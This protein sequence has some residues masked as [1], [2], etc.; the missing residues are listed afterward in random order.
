MICPV[1]HS[2]FS[3]EEAYCWNDGTLLIDENAEQ[4]TVVRPGFHPPI[5]GRTVPVDA[6]PEIPNNYPRGGTNPRPKLGLGQGLLIGVLAMLVV[7]LLVLCVFLLVSPNRLVIENENSDPININS[8][9]PV[10]SDVNR[11]PVPKKDTHNTNVPAASDDELAQNFHRVYHGSS[12]APGHTLQLKLDLERDG[13]KLTGSAET[14]DDV[15]DL[16][17]NISSDGSFSLEGYNPK[18]GRVTGTWRGQ[19]K[20]GS[21]SGVWTATNGRQISFSASQK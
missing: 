1:C 12:F 9:T 17:G 4:E 15:D 7:V 3:Q 11:T 19:I 16:S 6:T 13:D 20:N 14:P 2:V 10:N 8:K 21:I 5:V 18:A